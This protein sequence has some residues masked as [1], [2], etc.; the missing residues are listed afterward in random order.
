MPE[1]EV[2]DDARDQLHAWPRKSRELFQELMEDA[3]SELQREF[4]QR[5]VAAG[6]TAAEVHA[7]ADS[8]RALDDDEIFEACTVD[9]RKSKRDYSVMQLLKAESDPLY[10]FELKGGALS[11]A[12]DQDLSKSGDGSVVDL[13][14]SR[15]YQP[16]KGKVFDVDPDAAALMKPKKFSLQAESSSSR[17]KR[18]DL[19]DLGSSLD[20]A[21]PPS[22]SSPA[23]RPGGSGSHASLGGTPPP[24][25]GVSLAGGKLMED[26][27][28]ESTRALGVTFKEQDVDGGALTLEQA[29]IKATP[30]LERGVPIA[31]AL[32][33]APGQHRGFAV[34]LQTQ[35]S[36]KTRAL[37]LY[38]PFSQELVWA[39]EGILLA[40]VELPFGN[41]TNRRITRI[42]LPNAVAQNF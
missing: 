35:L 13:D 12:D 34:L 11:P 20:N 16:R 6:H 26:L 4:L 2:S 39:N 33:P 27:I 37:Q 38:N 21:R 30:S 24:P 22:G 25:S 28:N 29:L 9:D 10:A 3:G 18:V 32:G 14:S 1:F 19:N 23:L 41:K 31:V 42:A 17:L 40:R 5:A 7:F 36:G 8:L 15:E